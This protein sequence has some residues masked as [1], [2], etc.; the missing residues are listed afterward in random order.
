ML[1]IEIKSKIKSKIKK[2]TIGFLPKTDNA[3]MQ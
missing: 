1:N 3:F 2:H